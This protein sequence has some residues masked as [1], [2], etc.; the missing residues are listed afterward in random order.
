MPLQRQVLEFPFASGFDEKISKQVLDPSQALTTLSNLVSNQRGALAKRHG[1]TALTNAVVGGGT[2]ATGRRAFAYRDEVAVTDGTSL[3]SYSPQAAGWRNAGPVPECAVSRYSLGGAGVGNAQT[4]LYDVAFVSGY[5]CVLRQDP[6]TG[7][8]PWLLNLYVYD[9]TTLSAVTVVNVTAGTTPFGVTRIVTNG[10]TALILTNDG[11]DITA[12]LF[13]PSTLTV[14]TADYRPGVSASFADVAVFGTGYVLVYA[15]GT[16]PVTFHFEVLGPTGAGVN[17]FTTTSTSYNAA[18]TTITALAVAGNNANNFF[19]AYTTPG[20]VAELVWLSS[21]GGAVTSPQRITGFSATAINQLALVVV[22]AGAFPIGT[23]VGGSYVANNT[24]AASATQVT[25]L[26]YRRF[27]GSLSNISLGAANAIYNVTLAGRP[28]AVN[29]RVYV[30]IKSYDPTQQQAALVEITSDVGNGPLRPVA[31]YAARLSEPAVY[32]L[33]S[34]S[35]SGAML[36]GVTRTLTSK[37]GSGIVAS[38]ELVK[39]DF[40]GVS[41]AQGAAYAQELAL[42][43]GATQLYDGRGVF[44]SNFW[45]RPIAISGGVIGSGGG[46]SAGT[47]QFCAVFAYVDAAGNVERSAPSVVQSVV[48]TTAGQ[49][50]FFTIDSLPVTAKNVSAASSQNATIEIYRT[51]VNGTIFYYDLSTPMA[52]L[53]ATGRTAT[54][55]IT[56][57]TSDAVLQA[58]PQLYSQPGNPG[59]E[60]VHQSPPGLTGL[61]VHADRLVGIGDDGVTLWYSSQYISGALPWWQSQTVL[62]VDAGGRVRA[63]GSMLGFL[64]L[65]Q[66]DAIWVIQ[67]SGP[68]PNGGTGQEFTPPALLASDVGCIDPRSV[69]LTP[70]GIFFQSAR[71]IYLVDTSNNVSFI[72][73]TVQVTT[74]ANPVISSVVLDDAIGRVY[75]SLLPS[76]GSATGKRLVFDYVRGIWSTDVLDDATHGPANVGIVGA[77]LTGGY[78]TTPPAYTWITAAGRVYQE[79][80][81]AW[82][83]GSTWVEAQ[84]ETPPIHFAGILGFQRVWEVDIL[85]ERLTPHDILVEFAYD[86]APYNEAHTFTAAQIAA[87]PSPNI[88]LSVFPLQQRCRTIQV[89]VSDGSPTGL[90]VGNGQGSNWIG[91]RL[92]IGNKGTN[93]NSRSEE[94]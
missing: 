17:T 31:F 62:T 18:D 23:L 37:I 49:T 15:T 2:I 4:G 36:Y 78:A 46:T 30:Q 91:M 24:A 70:A 42:T 72:G 88:E 83:D 80:T 77:A 14:T 51:I 11:T 53:L 69:V 87:M 12:R 59:E 7:T 13:T 41:S 65:F 45:T 67:G 94:G 48:V 44:E 3:Y 38:I 47:Y 35:A 16:S 43:G 68:P 22:T 50:I 55:G 86:M 26:Y 19:F 89:R 61:I 81:A 60:L 76:E 6:S 54:Y 25:G 56:S 82:L 10:T 93:R 5:V 57:S 40:S 39:F 8:Y 29:G 32:C 28:A 74:A 92:Q 75:W 9:A 73:E 58:N 79:A 52:P 20:L 21:A 63:L 71:G 84:I 1:S 90:P 66:R 27:S 64:F 33:P 85:F 34:T